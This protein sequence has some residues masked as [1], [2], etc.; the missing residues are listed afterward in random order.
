[1]TRRTV[2][3][4]LDT[5]DVRL[6][7]AVRPSVGV[8]NLDPKRNAL[9]ANTAFCHWLHLLATLKLLAKHADDI[10]TDFGEKS[11]G[12]SKVFFLGKF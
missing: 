3:N 8:G 7:R 11:K 9:T 6:P 2:D 10:L 1:M 5:L 12:F 4:R